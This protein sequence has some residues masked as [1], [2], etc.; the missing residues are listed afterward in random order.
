MP[1]EKNLQNQQY[2]HPDLDSFHFHIFKAFAN[3]SYVISPSI[4]SASASESLVSLSPIIF[5]MGGHH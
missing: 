1:I 4:V 3:S 2:S 5:S